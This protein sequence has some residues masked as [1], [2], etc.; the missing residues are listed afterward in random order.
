MIR[1]SAL[2][3]LEAAAA[4]DGTASPGRR[5]PPDF[6]RRTRFRGVQVTFHRATGSLCPPGCRSG[7]CGSTVDTDDVGVGVAVHVPSTATKRPSGDHAPF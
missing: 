2:V 4:Q 3:G 5:A 1:P 7:A 6:D